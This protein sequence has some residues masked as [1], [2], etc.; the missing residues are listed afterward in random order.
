MA[1][2]EVTRSRIVAQKDYI[3]DKIITEED[4]T[5]MKFGIKMRQK[6]L[7]SHDNKPS[8][9]EILESVSAGV[10]GNKVP[11]NPLYLI[12]CDFYLTA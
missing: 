3:R 2:D 12:R 11:T 4:A 1:S 5:D 9:D 8:L 10:S 6:G 7:S